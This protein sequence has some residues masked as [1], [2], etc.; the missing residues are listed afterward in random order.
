[1]EHGLENISKNWLEKLV[2]HE[3]QH[4]YEKRNDQ[5]KLDEYYNWQIS[6]KMNELEKFHMH[7]YLLESLHV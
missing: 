2:E 5:E 7:I 4:E 6:S 1:M 3:K